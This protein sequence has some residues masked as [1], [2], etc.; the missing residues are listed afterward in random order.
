MPPPFSILDRPIFMISLIPRYVGIN[1]IGDMDGS[2][3]LI[4]NGGGMNKTCVTVFCVY[5]GFLSWNPHNWTHVSV[6]TSDTLHEAD[7]II[8]SE[9]ECLA[10]L[11]PAYASYWSSAVAPNSTFCAQDASN[12]QSVCYGDGGGPLVCH[13]GSNWNLVGVTSTSLSTLLSPGIGGYMS[14]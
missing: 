12:E 11:S 9:A 4:L 1:E 14:K 6:S 2:I 10:A 8:I 5:A 7:L 3:Y 13:D